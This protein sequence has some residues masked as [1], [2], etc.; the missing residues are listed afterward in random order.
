[1]EELGFAVG[2]SV[3]LE[4][5]I[6]LSIQSDLETIKDHHLFPFLHKHDMLWDTPDLSS[7]FDGKVTRCVGI[8][9]PA[10]TGRSLFFSCCWC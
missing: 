10:S 9:I 6:I 8:T 4:E 3:V 1:M 5:E 2:F 7:L